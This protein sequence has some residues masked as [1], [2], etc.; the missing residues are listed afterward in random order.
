MGRPQAPTATV[1]PSAVVEHALWRTS[2]K[3]LWSPPGPGLW[4]HSSCCWWCFQLHH[5]GR[6]QGF[7]LREKGTFWFAGL[8]FVAALEQSEAAASLP[9]EQSSHQ[10]PTSPS[11][12]KVAQK[13]ALL[14]HKHLWEPTVL[15]KPTVSKHAIESKYRKPIFFLIN[16]ADLI[17]NNNKNNQIP[18]MSYAIMNKWVWYLYNFCRS[19]VSNT[20][21][22][23]KP[24]ASKTFWKIKF[25]L[26]FWKFTVMQLI[27]Q[28]VPNQTSFLLVTVCHF[29]LPFWH[30]IW[31]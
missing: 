20:E 19:S 14:K 5:P 16:S 23:N 10:A 25:F 26:N 17:T 8:H 18:I 2:S 28:N 15:Y 6:D 1:S 21:L 4:L 24:Q 9:R 31:L 30:L 7:H 13:V 29:S 12:R 27:A 22:S 3:S 11:C